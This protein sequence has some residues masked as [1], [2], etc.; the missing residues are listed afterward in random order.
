MK[1]IFYTINLNKK[2]AKHQIIVSENSCLDL[3][4]NNEK[5]VFNEL[6]YIC[7]KEYNCYECTTNLIKSSMNNFIVENGIV[8]IN[9]IVNQI[10]QNYLVFFRLKDHVKF[11]ARSQVT[12]DMVFAVF[13]PKSLGSS[14]RLQIISKVSRILKKNNIRNAIKGANNA[15]DVIALLIT[16]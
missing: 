4:L 15:E 8:L 16:A 12:A 1:K 14:N 5:D 9:T 10:K 6:S 11:Y 13:T 2:N 3:V 7:K